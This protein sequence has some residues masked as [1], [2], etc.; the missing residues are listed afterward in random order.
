MVCGAAPGG[1]G[2]ALTV[3]GPWGRGVAPRG[4][5]QPWSWGTGSLSPAQA[6]SHSIRA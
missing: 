3:T 2:L 4:G 5:A 1:P 6:P